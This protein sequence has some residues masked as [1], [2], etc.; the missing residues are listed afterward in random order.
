MTQRLTTD[1]LRS[2]LE[3]AAGDV[4]G[5]DDENAFLDS[6]FD[7]LG[8]DSLALLETGSQIERLL[9]VRL[10]DEVLSESPTPR[11]LLA[12]VNGDQARDQVA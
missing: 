8:Y 4:E 10:A 5:V 1:Q 7:S 9:G 2:F 12:A 11:A 3:A 6:D